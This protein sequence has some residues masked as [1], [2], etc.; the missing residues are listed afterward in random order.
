MSELIIKM[1]NSTPL[2]ACQFPPSASPTS[3]YYVTFPGSS[4]AVSVPIVPM[5]CSALPSPPFAT[6]PAPD[7]T[8]GAGGYLFFGPTPSC[9]TWRALYLA[10]VVLLGLG[11]SPEGNDRLWM[12]IDQDA[13]SPDST[14]VEITVEGEGVKELY[15]GAI[16]L[17]DE[18]G[19]EVSTSRLKPK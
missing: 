19:D 5:L 15:E 14:A 11:K 9:S 10:D 13:E 8:Y 3:S 12:Q 4:S 16:K 18:T 1:P 6:F 2:R 17:S 7:A